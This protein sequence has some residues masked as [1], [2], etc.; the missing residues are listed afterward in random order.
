MVHKTHSS[1]SFIITVLMIRLGLLHTFEGGCSEPND[2]VLDTAMQDGP[3]GGFFLNADVC[4][5]PGSVNTCPDFRD[6]AVRNHMNIVPDICSEEFTDGQISRMKAQYNIWRK[7]T[8]RAPSPS[9]S[10]SSSSPSCF[11]ETATVSVLNRGPTKMADLRV[12]DKIPTVSGE[13]QPIYAFA[14]R[15]TDTVLDF[16]RIHTQSARALEITKDHLVFVAGQSSPVRAE[17]IQ[18]GDKLVLGSKQEEAMVTKIDTVKRQGLYAPLTADGTLVVDGIAT[19]CY[20]SLLTT[21]QTHQEATTTELSWISQHQLAHMM[22]S[23]IRMACLGISSSLC[24]ANNQQNGLANFVEIGIALV[25]FF[26]KVQHGWLEMLLS[27]LFVTIAGPLYV[28]ECMVGPRL[29]AITVVLVFLGISR[30]FFY[31]RAADS[32]MPVKKEL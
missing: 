25:D 14:H 18:P 5:E 32:T 24:D 20:V 6:D 2:F 13:Y 19:S 9:P 16:L 26:V 28:L 17:T 4:F 3:T 27:A 11:S 12:G 23:P 21:A 31:G 7:P 1:T 29:A 22:L 8:P 15:D 10:H 30:R